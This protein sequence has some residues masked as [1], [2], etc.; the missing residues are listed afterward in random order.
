MQAVVHLNSELWL[1][2]MSSAETIATSEIS[3]PKKLLE[4]VRDTLRR[5]A[6]LSVVVGNSNRRSI[7]LRGQG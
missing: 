1:M 6:T 7:I 5:E 2:D 3:K 4:Q